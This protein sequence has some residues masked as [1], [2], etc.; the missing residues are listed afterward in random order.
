MVLQYPRPRRA[1][2]RGNGEIPR[3]P[4]ARYIRAAAVTGGLS[5]PLQPRP[6]QL[7]LFRAKIP[8]LAP[9]LDGSGFNEG[10]LTARANFWL[11]F[12]FL[13]RTPS[14]NEGEIQLPGYEGKYLNNYRNFFSFS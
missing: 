7:P 9:E 10:L 4:K 11:A 6:A 5:P 2:R 1:T 13:S 3:K 14:T 8:L 12:L